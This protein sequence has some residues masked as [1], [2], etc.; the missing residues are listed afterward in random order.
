MSETVTLSWCWSVLLTSSWELQLLACWLC[1][2]TLSPVKHSCLFC[3]LKA[4]SAFIIYQLLSLFTFL[5]L[6]STGSYSYFHVIYD[7]A[8][9]SCSQSDSQSDAFNF[10]TPPRGTKAHTWQNP[11]GNAAALSVCFTFLADDISSAAAALIVTWLICQSN[12]LDTS[13]DNG[14]VYFTE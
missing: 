3:S 6:C 2:A 13:W 9:K 4:N 5:I 1:S 10:L 11:V 12:C 14:F 7:L 8:S